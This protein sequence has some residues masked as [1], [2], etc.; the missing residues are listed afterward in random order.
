MVEFVSYTGEYPNLCSGILTVKIDG[1]IVE[2]PK[3]CL[4]SMGSVNFTEDWAP[5]IESGDWAVSE[6]FLPAEY[7]H[8]IPEIEEVANIHI[9]H[10]CCGGCV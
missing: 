6:T 3:Y 7:H 9:P 2:L 5:I 1:E 8:L 10:G 4:R